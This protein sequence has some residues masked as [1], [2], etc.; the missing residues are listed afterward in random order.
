MADE[1][2]RVPFGEHRIPVL[3]AE[4]LAIC[5]ATFDRPRD[6]LD[7]EQML[8]TAEGIDLSAIRDWLVRIVGERDQ[9]VARFDEL[10]SRG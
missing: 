10:A 7:L 8:V 9:R 1:A 4:H 2:C 6:W 5:K 3:S